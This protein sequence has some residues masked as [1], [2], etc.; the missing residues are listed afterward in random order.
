MYYVIQFYKPT[1]ADKQL[2]EQFATKSA[3]DRWKQ[4]VK[5]NGYEVKKIIKKTGGK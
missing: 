1:S 5:K 2:E 4:L 3:A